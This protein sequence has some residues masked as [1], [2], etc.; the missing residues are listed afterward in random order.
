M[1][2]SYLN[3][4]MSSK[5]FERIEKIKKEHDVQVAYLNSQSTNK[6]FLLKEIGEQLA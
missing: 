2:V 4:A 5:A 3:H 1:N 6:D